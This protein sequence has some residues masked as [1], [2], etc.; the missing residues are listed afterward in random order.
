MLEDER[1]L[2]PPNDRELWKE[3][4]A[5]KLL[6]EELEPEVQQLDSRGG[7][8]GGERRRGDLALE[9]LALVAAA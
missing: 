2:D 5:E 4:G 9:A 3:E 7:D 6:R 1:L 8:G